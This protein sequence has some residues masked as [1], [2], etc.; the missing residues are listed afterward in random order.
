MGRPREFDVDKALDRAL[1]LF[2]RKGYEGT[3]LS[4]LTKALGINRP[5]LYAAFGNK[6][7]LFRKAVARYSE[8]PAAYFGEA[9]Q[10]PTARAAVE[11][12]LVA[13]AKL[14]TDPRYPR[15]CF[16]V[17]G[18]LACGAAANSVRQE[19][20]ARRAASVDLIRQRFARA[21]AE[22]DLPGD[23]DPC[24]LARFIAAVMHGMAVQAASG[25]TRKELQQ[26]AAMALNAWP[27]G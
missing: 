10:A 3:S 21:A 11:Q 9:L 5:S 13:T 26:V 20:I 27:V 8:G 2:W 24:A 14:L 6:E 15:G 22:G 25:A 19:L 12:L 4:D 16:L 1:R 23:V 18:A 7:E 17:Q